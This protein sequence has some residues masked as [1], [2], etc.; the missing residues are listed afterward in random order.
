MKK[1]VLFAAVAAL[2]A[3]SQKAEEAPAPADTATTDAMAAPADVGVAPGT[4]DVKD[5][6]GKLAKTVINADGTY[7]DTDPTGKVTKGTYTRKNGQD[8]F[9]EEGDAAEVCW[10]IT[11]PGADGSFTATTSDGKT[12]VTVTPAAMAP[13]T[14]ATPAPTAT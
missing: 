14:D 9:D 5:A 11:P 1:L 12:V 7:E 6:D 4:Y 13:T 2:S 3:C 8:C 10:N